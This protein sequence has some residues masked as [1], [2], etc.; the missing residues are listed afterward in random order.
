MSTKATKACEQSCSSVAFAT[1][2]T[3]S[4]SFASTNAQLIAYKLYIRA[5]RLVLIDPGFCKTKKKYF[6][7]KNICTQRGLASNELIVASKYMFI[8][9]ANSSHDM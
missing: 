8:F 4:L 1:S 7:P 9:T 3:G 6:L 5:P 2:K